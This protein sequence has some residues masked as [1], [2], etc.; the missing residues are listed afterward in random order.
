MYAASGLVRQASGF[1]GAH[2]DGAYVS[3]CSVGPVYSAGG[4]LLLS[5]GRSDVGAR[6]NRFRSPSDIAGPEIRPC[7]YGARHAGRRTLPRSVPA[8]CNLFLADTVWTLRAF[9]H[10]L[11]IS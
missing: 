2:R 1:L 11:A 4:V 5:L 8:I 3:G 9:R 6:I 10:G 7:G